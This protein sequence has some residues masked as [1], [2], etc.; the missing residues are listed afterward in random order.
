[1]HTNSWWHCLSKTKANE[2]IGAIHDG[3]SMC[4]LLSVLP[5]AVFVA[6]RALFLDD[7][8]VISKTRRGVLESP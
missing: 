7:T 6:C 8:M 4:A 5:D 3:R 1:M 2:S